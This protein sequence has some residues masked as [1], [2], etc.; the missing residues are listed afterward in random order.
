MTAMAASKELRERQ[1]LSAGLHLP[2][3][4]S[5]DLGTPIPSRELSLPAPFMSIVG[6]DIGVLLPTGTAR[7]GA[8]DDARELVAIGRLAEHLGCSSLFVN[9]FLVSPHIEALTM[10]NRAASGLPADTLSAA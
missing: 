2:E 9:D 3:P 4:R 10:P 8:A 5:T 6:M 7:W 1:A